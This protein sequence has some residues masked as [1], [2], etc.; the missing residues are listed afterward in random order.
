M[1][2]K[3]ASGGHC[4]SGGTIA[5]GTAMC[6]CGAWAAADYPDTHSRKVARKQHLDLVGV[7]RKQGSDRTE[8]TTR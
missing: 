2:P 3:Q 5:S 8:G 1:T 6:Q 4:V 7:M